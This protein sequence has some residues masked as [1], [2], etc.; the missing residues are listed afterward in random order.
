MRVWR[1]VDHSPAPRALL[2]SFSTAA[3]PANLCGEPSHVLKFS[4]AWQGQKNGKKEKKGKTKRRKS[5]QNGKMTRTTLANDRGYKFSDFVAFLAK[6]STKVDV[7]CSQAALQPGS[8]TSLE[9][10]LPVPPYIPPS[11]SGKLIQ[12][13]Y[14]VELVGRMGVLTRSFKLKVPILISALPPTGPAVAPPQMPPAPYVKSGDA[15]PG[16][17]SSSTASSSS[18]HG[19]GHDPVQSLGGGALLSKAM[20]ASAAA[21]NVYPPPGV[22]FAPSAA[23]PGTGEGETQPSYIYPPMKAP[24]NW[25]ARMHV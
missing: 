22:A 14:S 17:D 18:S 1:A 21:L 7:N 25:Y 10:R 23:L 3:G 11:T 9:C 6:I 12:I 13:D 19:T 4:M 5:R 15:A 2:L 16:F 20:D 8:A 24:P